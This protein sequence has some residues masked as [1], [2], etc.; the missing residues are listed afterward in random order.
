MHIVS[1]SEE[2]CNANEYIPRMS[3]KGRRIESSLSRAYS[4]CG[5]T[6]LHGSTAP[7]Y[8]IM[9]STPQRPICGQHTFPVNDG[10]PVGLDVVVAQL[11]H[12]SNVG[13]RRDGEML[14]RRVR[15]RAR[16]G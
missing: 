9:V 6:G 16:V 12:D 3:L 10:Q 4:L 2:L 14:T 5:V 8:N 15:L 13:E 7:P 1:P 11:V